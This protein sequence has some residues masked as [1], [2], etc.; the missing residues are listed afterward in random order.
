MLY[1]D[2]PAVEI[3]ILGVVGGLGGKR[4]TRKFWKSKKQ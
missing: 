4:R 1:S 2:I 3:I